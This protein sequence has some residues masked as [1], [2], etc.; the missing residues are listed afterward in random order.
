M[1]Q[2]TGYDNPLF[3]QHPRVEGADCNPVLDYIQEQ[4]ALVDAAA[5]VEE[6]FGAK[7]EPDERNAVASA[8][9]G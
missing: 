4:D 2:G 5:V 8:F 3:L 6:P 1:C 7:V 9:V